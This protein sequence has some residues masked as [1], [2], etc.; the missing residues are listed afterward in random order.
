M[1]HDMM[2]T[3]ILEEVARSKVQLSVRTCDRLQLDVEA[4]FVMLHQRQR[5]EPCTTQPCVLTLAYKAPFMN[6]MFKHQL[7]N[8]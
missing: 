2:Y 4:N 7:K 6:Q 1:H 3:L 8:Q 5:P